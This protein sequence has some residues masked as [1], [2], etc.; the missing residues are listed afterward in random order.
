MRAWRPGAR[1]A[2]RTLRRA[3]LRSR[4]DRGTRKAL[5]EHTRE[6]PHGETRGRDGVPEEWASGRSIQDGSRRAA[7]LADE[8][9]RRA[10]AAC[11][12]PVLAAGSYDGL[13]F[14]A[15]ARLAGL[16]CR[17]LQRIFP[18]KADMAFA[19]LRPAP[20]GPAGR[21]ALTLEGEVIVARYLRF[22]ETGDN[23]LVLRTLMC[24]SLHDPHLAARMEAHTI[25]TLIRPFAEEVRLT[26]AYPRAR[27]AVAQLLGLAVSRYLLPQEPLASADIETIASWAGPALDYCLRGELGRAWPPCGSGAARPPRD[28]PLR[29]AS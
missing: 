18:S 4:T 29:P 16:D 23:A 6:G 5:P 26:D 25:R 20:E 10:A 28:R 8:W 1:R 7:A 14:Q 22:W 19:A 2:L 13:T 24:A 11:V 27:L 17:D 21:S 9:V 15:V 12:A 3:S